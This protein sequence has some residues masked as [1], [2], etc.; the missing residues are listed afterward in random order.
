M[1][2]QA[3]SASVL[4]LAVLA[5]APE[6]RADEKRVC[7][8]VVFQR[9]GDAA[10]NEV[11]PVAPREAPKAAPGS[12]LPIGQK[13]LVYLKRLIE[14]FVTH[15]EGFVAV[16][17]SCEETIRV[18]LYP[19]Q[20]GWTVFARY[21][22]TGREERVDQLFPSELS[23]FAERS[24]LALLHDKPISDTIDRAN[25][26]ASDSKEYTQTIEGDHHF[27]LGVGT[28]LRFGRFSTA[29][30][31]GDD[32]DKALTA[33][34]FFAPVGMSLGY[35]GKFENWGIETMAQFGIETTKSAASTNPQGGHI[36][37]GGD[38]SIQLH[39]LHYFDP[40]GLTSLYLGGGTTFELLWFNAI[41][42]AGSRSDGDRST[43]L[44][45]GLD[46]DF[47]IGWEFMR[48][49]AVQFFLQGEVQVP[50]Y[51]L[52]HSNDDGSLYSYFPSIGVKLG[53]VF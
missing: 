15:E 24:V 31:E 49:S 5:G 45:G 3:W 23:P 32:K 17:E 14:H 34:R 26:L 39:F 20:E 53:V 48:A 50:C 40:R 18:E 52:N 47:V 43:L 38:A 4:A 33:W 2:R 35:R 28:Q 25:V 6:V 12:M 46:A 51:F 11:V 29:V 9:P 10:A 19:L 37:L 44:G 1:P 21:S 22:G 41:R 42:K 27:V 36:D 8:D 13:P 30:T 7:V 16:Q